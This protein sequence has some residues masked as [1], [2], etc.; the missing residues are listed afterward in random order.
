MEVRGP[1][2]GV[3]EAFEHP[4]VT[5]ARPK[6]KSRMQARKQAMLAAKHRQQ[7][8]KEKE[9]EKILVTSQRRTAFIWP[10]SP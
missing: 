9:Q 8:K 1:C 6:A 7:G 10:Y 5:T 4:K 2:V 3:Q